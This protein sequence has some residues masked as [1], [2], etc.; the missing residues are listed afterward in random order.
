M[1][2]EEFTGL[3]VLV[4]LGALYDLVPEI[5]D[6][7]VPDYAKPPRYDG[8]LTRRKGQFCWMSEMTLDDLT[9][10]RDK[11][12]ESVD[13]G[14]EFAERNEKTL[15]ALNH[16]VAWRTICPNDAWR[17]KRGDDWATGAVPTREVR[18]HSWSDQPQRS[19]GNSGGGSR[20]GSRPQP[21]PP[22]EQDISEDDIP[23]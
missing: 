5:Q 16:W 10:W 13:D 9:W 19:G 17:G 4:A 22:P 1:T 8:R 20:G 6:A 21:Q 12:Q 23:F 3:P 18:M 7:P 15:R 14:G 2:R 11:K